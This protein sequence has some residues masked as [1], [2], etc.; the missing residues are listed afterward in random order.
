METPST[1]PAGPVPEELIERYHKAID[2]FHEARENLETTMA[3]ID[4]R[5]TEHVHHAAEGVQ[6]AEREVE[7]L[8]PD[9]AGASLAKTR[10]NGP[11]S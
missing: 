2:Q 4:H 5:H 7:D 6:A 10:R 11:G 3:G 8:R 9:R 1:K